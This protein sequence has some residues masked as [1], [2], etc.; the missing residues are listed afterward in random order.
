[1]YK[2]QTYRKWILEGA[3]EAAAKPKPDGHGYVIE[4]AVRFDPCLEVAPGRFYRADMDDTPM[5]L[6]IAVGDLDEPEK[7]EGNFANFHHEDWLAGEKNKRTQ[8]RQWGTLWMMR[9]RRPPD[10]LG[11][12]KCHRM[13]TVTLTMQDQRTL[14]VMGRL[15]DGVLTA[16]QAAE[17][18][19]L[20]RTPPPVKTLPRRACRYSTVKLHTSPAVVPTSVSQLPESQPPRR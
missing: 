1:V 2:R 3:Q 7:G 10:A 20:C 4:W 9:G 8:R 19:C 15:A 11:Q 13:T 5:G 6:N 17:L 18:T 16:R 12:R 14:R